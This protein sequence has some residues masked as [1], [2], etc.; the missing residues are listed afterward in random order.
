MGSEPS[1]HQL[2]LPVDQIERWESDAR[3]VED[4]ITALIAR[5]D[6]LLKR[7]EAARFLFQDALTPAAPLAIEKVRRPTVTETWEKQIAEAVSGYTEGCT[8]AE[9]RSQIENGPLGDALRRSSK[10][11][12]RAMSRLAQRNEVKR[13]YGRVFT[14]EAFDRFA[15]SVEDGSLPLEKAAYASSPMSDAILSFVH[16]NPA[17]S[18][19]KIIFSL[20]TDPEFRAALSRNDSGAHN[21]IA[22]LIRRGFLIKREDGGKIPGPNFPYELLGFAREDKVSTAATAGTLLAGEAPASPI[23]NRQ[24][25]RLVG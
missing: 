9:L 10:T 8:Y 19:R 23:Q 6:D 20:K 17:S 18:N 11:Y 15:S 16:Q 7:V 4:Q 14:P 12:E 2:S 22:R 13:G 5:R 25:F 24:S 1:S 21:V 3:E